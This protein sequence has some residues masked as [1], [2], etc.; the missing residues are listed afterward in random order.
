[1][2]RGTMGLGL[3]S[4]ASSKMQGG[5]VPVEQDN[6]HSRLAGLSVPFVSCL[7]SA[8]LLWARAAY[9][10]LMVSAP[11]STHSGLF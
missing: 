8:G 9:A 11:T 6:G 2:A 1:M 7:G 5:T 10:A 4:N 3:I